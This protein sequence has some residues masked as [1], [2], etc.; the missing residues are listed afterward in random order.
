MNLFIETPRQASNRL[1]REIHSQDAW[2]QS[3]Q[4]QYDA[5]AHVAAQ[6]GCSVRQAHGVTQRGPGGVPSQQGS[7]RDAPGRQGP[8]HDASGQR[9]VIRNASAQQDSVC[10]AQKPLGPSGERI[11]RTGGLF[12]EPGSCAGTTEGRRSA[13]VRPLRAGEA[14]LREGKASE[15]V[16]PGENGP[17]SVAQ[18]S[19]RE[20]L[21]FHR[22][23][24]RRRK[25]AAAARVLGL[26]LLIPLA[27]VAV[28]VGSY[29]LTCVVN[30]ASPD[31]VLELVQ[32]MPQRI[33]SF[34]RTMTAV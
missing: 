11:C 30:G 18:E 28:F 3:M 2:V 32:T 34:V 4:E 15:H 25:L 8:V 13:D 33:E 6:Q 23:R 9:E 17:Y 21:A 10:V 20:E 22:E 7:V 26:A 12:Q 31:E 16:E 24:A 27:L 29:V 14:S 5:Q 19:Y 1:E